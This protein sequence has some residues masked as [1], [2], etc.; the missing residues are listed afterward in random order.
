MATTADKAREHLTTKL[1][2]FFRALALQLSGGFS[3]G[4]LPYFHSGES[5]ADNMKSF[6]DNLRQQIGGTDETAETMNLHLTRPEFMEK[7]LREEDGKSLLDLLEDGE[8]M[9]CERLGLTNAYRSEGVAYIDV[10]RWN[11]LVTHLR[12]VNRYPPSYH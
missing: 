11:N 12:I 1:K 10:P 4:A 6:A 7:M 3:A 8:W 9:I 2:R 5:M